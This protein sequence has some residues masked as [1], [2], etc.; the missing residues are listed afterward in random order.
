VERRKK[1]QW[2]LYQRVGLGNGIVVTTWER[3]ATG[4]L[5][6]PK[7]VTTKDFI[8]WNLGK[9]RYSASVCSPQFVALHRGWQ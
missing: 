5:K 3:I 1:I 8:R 4:A 2:G 7:L 9:P 6:R